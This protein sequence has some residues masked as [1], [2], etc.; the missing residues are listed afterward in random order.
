MATI[1]I[2]SS[3]ER[4]HLI[5]SNKYSNYYYFVE[6]FEGTREEAVEYIIKKW[7]LD[8][9]EDR[10]DMYDAIKCSGMKDNDYYI[11]IDIFDCEPPK[12]S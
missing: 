3:K 5:K 10:E 4:P 11:V 1:R 9:I 8:S 2:Q 7:E 12:K 6:K